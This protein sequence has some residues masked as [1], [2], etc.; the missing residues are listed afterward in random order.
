MSGRVVLRQWLPPVV[1]RALGRA[2]GRSLRFVG[3]WSNWADAAAASRGYD[4]AAILRRI[5]AATRE[6][7]AGRASFERD[8]VLFETWE[9]PFQLLAPLLRHALRHGGRL[10]VVD[11]GGSL[12]STYRQCRPFLPQLQ[13]LQWHVV[14]QAGF[15]DAGRAEF[16]RPPLHFHPSL[17]SLPPA[18]AP[19]LL[20]ASSVLQYLPQPLQHLLDWQEHAIDTIVLDRTPVWNGPDDRVCVQHVPRHIYDASYPC[21]VLSRPRLLD[22]LSRDFRLVC[23]FDCPEGRH[24][25]RGGPAFDFKG[26]VWERKSA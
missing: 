14:E 11:F 6:V 9:P 13:S 18:S 20:L 25:P 16:A 21:W 7:E 24:V 26:F 10:E 22:L 4:D 2:T 17:A 1:H 3:G 15:V 8:G 5:V 19:R 23:E 12:G